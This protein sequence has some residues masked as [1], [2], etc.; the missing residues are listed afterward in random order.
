MTATFSAPG[1]YNFQVLIVDAQGAATTSSV[2]VVVVSTYSGITVS[3]AISTL[4]RAGAEQFSA[5]AVD[6]FGAAMG[7]QPSFTWSTVG[8]IGSIDSS[9]N[10]TAPTAGIGTATIIATSSGIS[11]T[12]TVNLGDELFASVPGPQQILPN[13]QASFADGNAISIGDADAS[14]AGIGVS[15]T[16]TATDGVMTLSGETGLAFASGTGTGDSTMTFSG[17]LTDLDNALAG[18]VFTP[19][20][21]FNGS[22]TVQVTIN[23]VGSLPSPSKTVV[24]NVDPAAVTGG[25]SAGSSSGGPGRF[26]RWEQ[27]RN[28][29]GKHRQLADANSIAKFAID[30]NKLRRELILKPGNITHV[31]ADPPPHGAG[32]ASPG[33]RSAPVNTEQPPEPAQPQH[34]PPPKPPSAGR[35]RGRRREQGSGDARSPIVG[36]DPKCKS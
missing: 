14:T 1:T 34:H 21:N 30:T 33:G 15:V 36:G 31:P 20:A 26:R 9:G 17:S 32:N 13:T 22:A 25:S 7:S 16:L 10:Y 19:Q 23:E 5:T 12:A 2:S 28:S 8:S 6:Q 3:P 27:F 11:G 18:M 29:S 4:E 24:I 35:R